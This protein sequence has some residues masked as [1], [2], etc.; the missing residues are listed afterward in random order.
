MLRATQDTNPHTHHFGY[1]TLT[2]FGWPF[3]CHSP[4]A[5]MLSVGPTT[6][7][8][9]KPQRFG[10]LRFRSPL[11]T[12]LFLLLRVLRCFSSP[13]SP[14]TGYVFT[15]GWSGI[16]RTGFPHSDICGS[17]LYHNSPQL[18][19]VIHVLLRP[20]TPRHPPY[21]LSSLTTLLL[22]TRVLSL[23]RLLSFQRFS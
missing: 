8:Q 20:L 15:S 17:Q 7:P 16:P 6:P 9:S 11:L 22:K 12:E 23:Q 19:A 5:H 3:Q 1:G 4:T 2:P 18:F 21:A 13:S 14:L 10:L